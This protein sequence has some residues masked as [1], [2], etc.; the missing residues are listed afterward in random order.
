MIPK[1][2]ENTINLIP[3]GIINV[4]T[5]SRCEQ[6]DPACASEHWLPPLGTKGQHSVSNW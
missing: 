3:I 2:R 1:Q 4:M 5:T 6:A